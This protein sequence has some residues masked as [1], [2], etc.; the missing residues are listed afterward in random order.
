MRGLDVGADTPAYIRGYL[1]INSLTSS[2]ESQNW[3]KGYVLL[4]KIVGT[5]T[6]NNPYWLLAIISAVILTGIGYFIIE[7][8]TP[9]QS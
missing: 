3:E 4:N 1:N 8:T 7:N 5:I 9:A 2:W 6:G